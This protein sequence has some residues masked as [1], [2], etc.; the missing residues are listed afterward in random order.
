MKSRKTSRVCSIAGCGKPHNAHGWCINH[1]SAWRRRG[2]PLAPNTRIA[3]VGPCIVQ[4]CEMPR[5]SRGYC[6]SHYARLR[7]YGPEG[8]AM[9]VARSH[10][11]V[12][13][14]STGG[15]WNVLSVDH[16]HSTGDARGVLCNNCNRVLG[17]VKDD[18]DL[19]RALAAYL[20][21][22]RLPLSAWAE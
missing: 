21:A 12:C 11:D 5:R 22:A 13:G 14:S 6:E 9:F 4:G 3:R 10:C 8:L 1:Y 2:D 15:R 18:A 19:L 17:F 16:D 20:D 7:R